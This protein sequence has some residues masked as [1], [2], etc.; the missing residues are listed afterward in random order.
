MNPWNPSGSATVCFWCLYIMYGR[1][2][3][4]IYSKSPEHIYNVNEK[5]ITLWLDVIKSKIVFF[6][7]ETTDYSNSNTPRL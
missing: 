5:I 2:Q 1:Y 6:K 7:F 3:R 4:D